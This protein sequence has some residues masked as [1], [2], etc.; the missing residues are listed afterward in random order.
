M[1]KGPGPHMRARPLCCVPRGTL[2]RVRHMIKGRPLILRLKG[3]A[4]TCVKRRRAGRA[5]GRI[6]TP[7]RE[8][9]PDRAAFCVTCAYG[10]V[11]SD[12]GRAPSLENTP[13]GDK[14]RFWGRTGRAGMPA[15]KSTARPQGRQVRIRTGRTGRRPPDTDCEMRAPEAGSVQAAHGGKPDLR[16]GLDGTAGQAVKNNCST[17]NNPSFS[18]QGFML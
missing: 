12:C 14:R 8:R 16:M 2:R 18:S 13:D 6:G 11:A 9:A 4:Q 5:P 3:R 1:E 7:R 10:A 17:W 15:G